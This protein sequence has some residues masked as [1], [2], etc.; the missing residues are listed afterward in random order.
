MI[1]EGGDPAL[2][3]VDIALASSYGAEI[4][5][6][7]SSLL[8]YPYGCIEQTISSTLSSRI[9]LSLSDTLSLS[10]D[11]KKAK[12]HTRIG[13]EKILRMQHFGG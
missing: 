13:L 7:L 5:K 12:E 11:E 8:L 9:A 1:L 6:G 4:N 3:E 2:S 10:I